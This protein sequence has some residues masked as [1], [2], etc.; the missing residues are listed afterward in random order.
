MKSND[1]K[2]T[3]KGITGE[4][5]NNAV[6][7]E[8]GSATVYSGVIYNTGKI[9]NGITNSTFT[10]NYVKIASGTVYGGAIYTTTYLSINADNGTSVFRGN[11]TQ[12]GTGEKDYNAIYVGSSYATL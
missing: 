11:Y 7:K 10:D 1:S 9:T 5:V 12:V 4:F 6:I 8:T 2:S 3:I